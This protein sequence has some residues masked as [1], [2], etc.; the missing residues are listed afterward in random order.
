MILA[1]QPSPSSSS[2]FN[3][4]VS[5]PTTKLRPIEWTSVNALSA[6]MGTIN[7]AHNFIMTNP[8]AMIENKPIINVVKN[9]PT[10]SIILVLSRATREWGQV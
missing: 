3:S 1:N 7:H 2:G 8:R 4:E 6:K 9:F 10:A 5:R